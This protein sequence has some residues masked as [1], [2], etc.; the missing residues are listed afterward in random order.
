MNCSLAED[1]PG[2]I[3]AWHGPGPT[4]RK[5]ALLKIP[6]G[7]FFILRNRVL[8]SSKAIPMI[9]TFLNPR[10]FSISSST[11]IILYPSLPGVE[12]ARTLPRVFSRAVS[13]QIRP[14]EQ[15]QQSPKS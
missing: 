4:S 12:G 5:P 10:P 8:V 1:R 6:A 3:T 7:E 11:S 2:S 14:Q 9:L 15:I 13:R